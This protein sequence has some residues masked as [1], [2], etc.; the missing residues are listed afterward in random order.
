M[1]DVSGRTFTRRVLLVYYSPEARQRMQAALHGQ[2]LLEVYP[3]DGRSPEATDA[4]GKHPAEVVV[5]DYG[6]DDLSVSQAVRQVGQVLPRSLVVAVYPGR[7]RVD[8]YRGGHRIGAAESLEA[9]LS[10]YAFPGD[11][12]AAPQSTGTG[13]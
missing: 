13:G 1:A 9:A 12:E 5:I 11:S 10:R 7:N 2:S 8:V 6:A 4:V 3:I